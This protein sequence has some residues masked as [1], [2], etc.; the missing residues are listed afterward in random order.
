MAK[1]KQVMLLSKNESYFVNLERS[2]DLNTKSGI[3]KIKELKKKIFG[4]RIKTHLGK[5]FYIIN[6]TILDKINKKVKRGA[7]VILPKDIG[8]ILTYTGLR[9]DS[10][11]ID[12]GAGSAYLSMFIANFVP[13][14][15]VIS[16]EN[17]KR[18]FKLA[19]ENVK[20]SGLKNIKIKF[21]DATKGLTDKN[22]DLVTIDIQHPEKVIK[23]SYKSLKVGGYLVAYSPTVEELIK[24]ADAIK[25]LNFSELKT[26]ENIVREWQ[27]ERTT[28][29]KTMGLMHTG[30]ITF[31]RKVG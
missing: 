6:P 22:A 15:K 5:E 20:V 16:Y 18:F 27:T 12:I 23:H 31:A 29:P 26:V 13:N 8:I 19:N 1:L 11:V 25:K 17:D 14:G 10:K 21:K 24:V 2:Q 3:I 28:R 7:Q 4:S 30:F 9:P